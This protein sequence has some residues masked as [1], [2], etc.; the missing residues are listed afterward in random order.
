VGESGCG[1]TT[2]ARCITRVYEPQAGK[3]TFFGKD[4]THLKK[5]ALDP[6]RPRISLIFQ[7][8]FSS[9]DPR[10]NAG[11]IV[12][13]ALKIHKLVKTREEYDKRVCELFELVGLDP[14]LRDRFPHEFSGGQRQRIG[15][16]RA[17]S[18]NPD[19]IICDEPVSAVDVSI[20]A[21]IIN[22]LENLQA[23]LGVAYLFIAHDLAVVKHLSDRVMVTYLGRIMEIA[24]STELYDNPKHPYTKALLSSVPIADPEAEAGREYV[25][26][27]GEVPSVMNRP[28]G[29]PFSDRCDYQTERCHR[30]I[31]ESKEVSPGHF[32]HCFLH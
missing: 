7:D 15:V 24:E 22:L 17:L 25:P 10:Q 27:R 5:K 19:I 16:A 13:E 29:C 30:Q 28:A 12:G 1:K 11:F 3:I 23:E 6:I 14:N 26:M 8:P 18:S 21:Q 4:I 31:P 9:L 20:Q 2:L 32:V